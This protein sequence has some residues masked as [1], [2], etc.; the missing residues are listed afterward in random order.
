MA[1]VHRAAQS[2]VG[3]GVLVVGTRVEQHDEAVGSNVRIRGNRIH[4]SYSSG[5]YVDGVDMLVEENDI[6]DAIYNGVVAYDADRLTVRGNSIRNSGH[7]GVSVRSGDDVDI[8]GNV[9][10]DSTEDGIELRSSGSRVLRN[11]VLSCAGDRHD[12]GVRIEGVENEVEDN[13]VRD[14][15]GDGFFVVGDENT[16]RRNVAE[17]C[18]ADG[19][20]IQSGNDNFVYECTASDCEGEALDNSGN[21]TTVSDSTFLRSRILLGN[22]GTFARFTGNNVDLADAVLPQVD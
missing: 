15:A 11:M 18:F 1:G 7:H 19:I 16:L 21:E 12:A 2:A 17:F 10:R 22:D 14:S 13:T 3:A 6:R 5:V 4:G 20:D 8:V 9:I